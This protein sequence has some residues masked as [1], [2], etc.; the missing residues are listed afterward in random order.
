MHSIKQITYQGREH[1]DHEYTEKTFT[2]EFQNVPERR[3]LLALPVLTPLK[4][5]QN[6]VPRS[7]NLKQTYAI[8]GC[9]Y[10]WRGHCCPLMRVL[11][12]WM[13]RVQRGLR[14][15]WGKRQRVGGMGWWSTSGELFPGYLNGEWVEDQLDDPIGLD[16][17][18]YL[19]LEVPLIC[20]QSDSKSPTAASEP[21]NPSSV[22]QLRACP[23]HS[24]TPLHM[25]TGIFTPGSSRNAVYV[26]NKRQLYQLESG[27]KLSNVKIYRDKWYSA[28]VRVV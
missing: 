7:F 4:Q 15:V 28:D 1:L 9:Q 26:I 27:R 24:R 12:H 5:S 11:G 20:H 19:R 25:E 6:A 10:D 22:Y 13:G 8:A 14:P 2:Y 16:V 17:I 21:R 3:P 18:L 23:S